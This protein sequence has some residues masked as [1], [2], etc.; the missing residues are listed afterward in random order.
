[1]ITRAMTA[2]SAAPKQFN[3]HSTTFDF[4]SWSIIKEIPRYESTLQDLSVSSC[5]HVTGT[6]V[7]DIMCSISGLKT[8]TANY[9]KDTNLLEDTR[10]WLS[11]GMKNLSWPLSWKA[12]EV[13]NEK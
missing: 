5:S 3:V 12:Q 10:P 13:L 8:F 1:M 9:I 4:A 6:M 2:A 7:H 11:L